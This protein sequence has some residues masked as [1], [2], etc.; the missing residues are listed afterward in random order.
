M[1]QVYFDPRADL[2][3]DSFME[4]GEM[5][6]AKP[7]PRGVDADYPGP[8]PRYEFLPGEKAEFQAV[9]DRLDRALQA[10]GVVPSTPQEGS[11]PKTYEASLLKALA[12]H[13]SGRASRMQFSPQETPDGVITTLNR[14]DV[15]ADALTEPARQGRLAHIKTT[16]QSG[17]VVHEYVGSK[18]QWMSPFKGVVQTGPICIDQVPQ[19]A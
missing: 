13:T 7:V 18:A 1:S 14:L 16:D 10:T 11:T 9:R 12:K 2:D 5:I 8:Y 6:V 19:R 4:V 17:R 15:V 3:Y